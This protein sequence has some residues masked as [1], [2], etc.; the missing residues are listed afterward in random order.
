MNLLIWDFDG[1]LG[2][3]DSVM[4]PGAGAWTAALLETV[5]REAPE[6]PA[7]AEELRPYIRSGFPWHTPELAHPH[8]DTADTWWAALL[9][10]FERAYEGVG[11]NHEQALRLARRVRST[12][13][14]PS[15]WH[16]FDDT[17][18]ALSALAEAGWTHAVLSNHVPELDDLIEALGL[19]SH[20]SRVFNSAD[21]GVEKPNP[22]AFRIALDA[23]GPHKACW[24]I[25]DSYRADVRGA[26]AVGLP[27]ILVRRLHPDAARFA[28]TLAEVGGLL[29]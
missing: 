2:Y 1:T 22:E 16:V 5:Q 29:S 11:L 3:R 18:S 21:I 9:P 15:R 6:C 7:T 10:V 27:S 8:L 25:G 20:F 17:V 28:P 4:E 23:V 14:D 19:T 24:M 26:E 12:Y 13:L